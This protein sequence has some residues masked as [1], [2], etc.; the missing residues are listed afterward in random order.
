MCVTLH[1]NAL[2]TIGRL[3]VQTKPSHIPEDTQT[4]SLVSKR[5]QELYARPVFDV[6][7]P[8]K[9]KEQVRPRHRPNSHL[10]PSPALLA[11]FLSINV[12]HVDKHVSQAREHIQD[13]QVIRR[14]TPSHLPVHR[15][16]PAHKQ[17]QRREAKPLCRQGLEIDRFVPDL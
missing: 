1:F 7:P 3:S 9:P 12:R 13:V 15:H 8:G 4:T 10:A 11:E 5:N 6:Q 17:H 14:D 2:H 16:T